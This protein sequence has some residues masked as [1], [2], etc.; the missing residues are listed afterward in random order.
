MASMPIR[1]RAARLVLFAL[2][3]LIP[4]AARGQLLAPVEGPPVRL[5]RREVPAAGTASVEFSVSRFGRYAI[6]TASDRGVAL[7]LVR[8]SAGPGEADGVPGERDGRIDVFLEPGTY[9]LR[10]TGHPRAPGNAR[11][12]VTPFVEKNGDPLPELLPL[13]PVDTTLEDGEQR[14][15]WLRVT[16]P[17]EPVVVEAAGRTLGELSLWR[18]GTWRRVVEVERATVLPRPGRPLRV[19]RMAPHL[20]PGLYLLTASGGPPE[21]WAEGGD[22]APLHLRLGIPLLPA[23]GRSRRRV[24]PMGFDRWLLPGSARLV[25]VDLPG[26]APLRL[27]AALPGDGRIQG[28]TVAEAEISRDSREPVARLFPGVDDSELM[29]ITVEGRAGQPYLLQHLRREDTFPELGGEVWAG[30]VRTGNPA[31]SA[32]VTAALM[33]VDADNRPVPVAVWAIRPGP[34]E[35]WTGRFNLDGDTEIL[36]WADRPGTYTV[37]LEGTDAEATLEPFPR[38]GDPRYRRPDPRRGRSAWPLER[39]LSVLTLHP[40]RPGIVEVGLTPGSDLEEPV[41]TKLRPVIVSVSGLAVEQI[42]S[43]HLGS[44]SRYRLLAAG[45]PGVEAGLLV[46][47]LPIRA[48]DPLPLALPAGE[49]LEVPV[50]LDEPSAMVATS[51]DGTP[52]T[53]FVDGTPATRE[54]VLGAGR[55]AVRVRAPVSQPLT[56]SLQ[57]VPRRLL[58]ATPLPALPPDVLAGRPRLPALEVG[59]PAYFELARGGSLD[60]LLPLARSADYTVRSTGLLDVT[61]VLTDRTGARIAADDDSGSG[62]N[63]SMGAALESGLYGL[64]VEALGNSAGDFG[65]VVRERPPTEGGDLVPGTIRRARVEAGRGLAYTVHIPRTG[66]Y[67]LETLSLAGTPPC[68][69]EDARGWPLRKPGIPA[70]F[71]TEFEAGELRLVILPAPRERTLV[72]VLRA[73]PEAPAFTGHGPHPL[74]LDT[75]VHHTWREPA[76][77]GERLPD[78]WTVELP[79]DATVRLELSRG[80]VARLADPAGRELAASREGTLEASL[81]AGRYRLEV[82]AAVADD[83]RPYTLHLTTEELLP[84]RRRTVTAPGRVVLSLPPGVAAVDTLAAVDTRARLLDAR[85]KLVASCDDRPGDWNPGFL[86]ALPGGRYTLELTPLDRGGPVEVSLAMRPER[87]HPA[88]RPPTHVILHPGTAV[89]VIPLE[90]PAAGILLAEARSDTPVALALERREGKGWRAAGSARGTVASLQVPLAGGELRLRLW[91]EEG[92]ATPVELSLA[93]ARPDPANLHRLRQGLTPRPPVRSHLATAVAQVDLG[94]PGVLALDRPVEGLRAADRPGLSLHPVEGPFVATVSGRL[95]LA[96]PRP[97]TLRGDRLQLGDTPVTLSVGG[98]GPVTVDLPPG[99]GFVLLRAESRA[100]TPLLAAPG[101]GF[102]ASSVGDGGAALVLPAGVPAVRLRLGE[103]GA[104]GPVT[105]RALRFPSPRRGELSGPITR[106][107]VPPE[108]LVLATGGDPAAWRVVT[109]RGVTAAPMAAGAPL[110]TLG[111]GSAGV[112]ELAGTFEAFLLLPETGPPSAAE[113][114]RMPRGEFPEALAEGSNAAAPA[115]S[116]GRLRLPLRAPAGTPVLVAGAGSRGLVVGSRGTLLR[117]SDLWVPEGGGVLWLAH[118]TAASAAWAGDTEALFSSHP[119][120]RPCTPPCRKTAAGDA[121]V[122]ALEADGPSVITLEPGPGSLFQLR[123]GDRSETGFSSRGEPHHLVL[124]AGPATLAVRALLPGTPAAVRVTAAALRT[125]GEGPGPR[126]LLGPGES[127]A[128]SFQVRRAAKVGLG[129]RA[130]PDTVTAT[131]VDSAGERI[132]EGIVQLHRLEPGTYILL[133]GQPGDAGPVTVQPVLAGLEPPPS[134]P[135]E[136]TVRHYLELSGRI[137]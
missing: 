135:P 40:R 116:G 134:A 20:E 75:T 100:G 103:A 132:G 2:S 136:E 70:R 72:T 71:E 24:G 48:G 129:V 8:R 74:P 19:I 130:V 114:R 23:T 62:L 95:W 39:G 17:E 49:S 96:V 125:T 84:G 106:V 87:A 32:P 77:G 119:P 118:G 93:A 15:W 91:S 85:G 1:H 57:A 101:G 88:A 7:Q 92:L 27:T 111:G 26:S 16:D 67:R 31:D 97:V 94:G 33:A 64:H 37:E 18:D 58:A 59:R 38:P 79:A 105:L 81:A 10:T 86:R 63:F 61:A 127:A 117:G 12:E 35:G 126:V 104:A 121:L 45:V 89:E 9:L 65:V 3:L 5:E 76:D 113:L 137:R 11:L 54:T 28:P 78:L 53:V 112:A 13:H 69:L 98:D 133:V 4:L 55:H 44:A 66:R 25:R 115:G 128:F 50:F 47:A 34:D 30:L 99:D 60:L 68:R 80:M 102:D 122:L 90:L 110:L 108:G 29:V 43:L 107:E 109:G 14:S 52:V 56:C 73:L 46:R 51:E 6:R 21:P 120:A 83:R 131:L 82:R 36:V 42:P 22:A 123:Q 124:S 41:E